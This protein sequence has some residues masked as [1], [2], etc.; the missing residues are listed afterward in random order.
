MEFK[1]ILLAIGLLA[2]ALLGFIIKPAPH[3]PWEGFETSTGAGNVSCNASTVLLDTVGA[4]YTLNAT[5]N[6]T[7]TNCF[8]IT[9]ANVT[10]DC[11]G[12]TILGNNTTAIS[13][14]YS[15]QFNTTIKNCN[16]R[17]FVYGIN[18]ATATN[19]TISNSTIIAYGG[20]SRGIMLSTSTGYNTVVNSSATG[21]LYGMAIGSPSHRNTVINSTFVGTASAAVLLYGDYNVFTGNSFRGASTIGAFFMTNSG[22]SSNNNFTNNVFNGTGSTYSFGTYSNIPASTSNFFMNNTFTNTGIYISANVTATKFCLNNFTN[23]SGVYVTDLNGSYYNATCNGQNQGNIWFNLLNGSVAVNGSTRSVSFPSLYVGTQGTDYPYNNSTSG[24]KFLCNF[25]GCAD[26]APL[27]NVSFV[28]NICGSL[29]TANTIYTMNNNLTQATGTCFTV[30]ADNVTLDCAGRTITGGNAASNYAVYTNR[31]NTTIKNCLMQNFSEAIY[32]TSATNSSVS[33][34]TITTNR[35]S[36]RGIYLLTSSNNTFANLTLNAA[37]QSSKGIYAISYSLSNTFTNITAN[38][39]GQSAVGISITAFSDYNNL[40]KLNLY[41]MGSSASSIW[42]DSQYN[43]VSNFTSLSA[44]IS[45]YLFG[46]NNHFYNFTSNSSDA[47]GIQTSGTITGNNVH[48]F[49]IYETS[50]FPT[51]ISNTGGNNNWTNFS[52]TSTG[53]YGLYVQSTNG[54]RFSNFQ[55]TATGYAM[56]LNGNSNGNVFE[57]FNATTGTGDAIVIEGSTNNILNNFKTAGDN[58]IRISSSSTGNNLT[59]GNATHAQNSI[60]IYGGSSG[61]LVE[62]VTVSTTAGYNEALRITGG[63]NGNLVKNVTATSSA[64]GTTLISIESGAYNNT[65]LLSKL[66]GPAD[67]GLYLESDTYSNSFCLNNFTNGSTMYIQDDGGSN[68]F[69]CTYEG[70]NQGNIYANVLNGSVNIVSD[71]SKPSSITALYLGYGGSGYPYSNATAKGKFNCIVGNGCFDY[72]PL[73]NATW[74]LGANYSSAITGLSLRPLHAWMKNV[75]P[76]NQSYTYPLYVINNSQSFTV[77]VIGRITADIPGFSIKCADNYS[78]S[79]AIAFNSSFKNVSIVP[80]F[81]ATPTTCYQETATVRGTCGA[82]PTGSYSPSG[83]WMDGDWATSQNLANS[84]VYVNYSKSTFASSATLQVKFGNATATNTSNVSLT[85]SSSMCYQETANVSTACGGLATGSYANDSSWTGGG[86]GGAEQIYDANWSSYT[87]PSASGANYYVNYTRPTGSSYGSKWLVGF[88]NTSGGVH[89]DYFNLTVN[90]SCL[91][92]SNLRLRIYAISSMGYYFANMSCWDGSAWGL[93]YATGN[94]G[95]YYDANPVEE[96]MWWNITSYDCLASST[97]QFKFQ[98]YNQSLGNGALGAVNFTTTTKTYGSMTSPADYN[99]S[100][101][102]LYLALDRA[103]NF[104]NF[105][106]GAGTVLSTQS[107]NGT[108]MV[109]LATGTLNISG[110]INLTG[111]GNYTSAPYTYGSRTFTAKANGAYGNGGNGGD[112]DGC[113]TVGQGGAGNGTAGTGGATEYR[114]VNYGSN[115]CF[116][117][118]AG[119]PSAGGS[120]TG[121]A[122]DRGGG[123][124]WVQTGAGGNAFGAAGTSGTCGGTSYGYNVGS[125]GGGGAG[126]SPGL[127]GASIYIGANVANINGTIITTGTTGMNG[128]AGGNSVICN[129]GSYGIGANGGNGGGGG[130]GGDIILEYASASISSATFNASGASGGTGGAYGTGATNGANGASGAVGATGTSGNVQL[131]SIA[132]C[133]SNSAWSSL[134]QIPQTQI[135]SSLY[136]E[137]IYW[138]LAAQNGQGNLWC[139]ADFDNPSPRGQSFNVSIEG[140]TYG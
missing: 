94:S 25:A 40:S 67:L 79:A 69:N 30:T 84:E 127:S 62:N 15:T 110:I 63:A 20:T 92:S 74:K 105:T 50:G 101:N 11:R 134:F 55:T 118:H 36:G 23:M 133:Y 53:M 78:T 97:A 2:L 4:T 89:V 61:N 37:A 139:W 119:G 35:N 72:A 70:K 43:T 17:S 75:E 8:N 68:F 99:V 19:S 98:Y 76:V 12:N 125:G 56:N 57:N 116:A 60:Y 7:G 45:I 120:G 14:I 42:I 130:S 103:Y 136:E 88:Y 108:V 34:S 28:P 66:S 49:S 81:S 86:T 80:P 51:I 132:S 38:A 100:G 58:G 29:S 48:D 106:L 117:G 47:T 16:V 111:K 135:M 85:G 104:T 112:G 24:G 95:G 91:S 64:T 71:T 126:G 39:S 41:S 46:S 10:L 73:T 32:F 22:S 65:V 9:A 54:D 59:N 122:D 52:I 87:S 96:G 83:A 82:L 1:H 90:S 77:Q 107:P 33:N 3:N 137:G 140:A 129:G 44:Y 18:F 6:R 114:A 131:G 115:F 21:D 102:T 109:I 113:G 121:Y 128:G 138:T 31:F 5:N 93:I 123:G 13:G 26:R 27:T 124:G